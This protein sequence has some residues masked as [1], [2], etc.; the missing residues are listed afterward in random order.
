MREKLSFG[1]T[2]D[3]VLLQ[4]GYSTV[5]PSE[6]DVSTQLTRNI[7]INVPLVSSPMDTVT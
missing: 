1:I 2:F 3:D 6:V 5:V 4:P 7:A